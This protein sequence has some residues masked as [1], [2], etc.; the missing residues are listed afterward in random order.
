MKSHFLAD[1]KLFMGG[2]KGLKDAWHFGVLL[3]EYERLKK[4]QEKT[5]ESRSKLRGIKHSF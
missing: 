1:T 5:I 4:I 2:V 3:V